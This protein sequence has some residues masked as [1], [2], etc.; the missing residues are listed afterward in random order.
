VEKILGEKSPNFLYSA[1]GSKKIRVFLRNYKL[2]DDIGFR[3]SARWWPEWPLTADKYAGWLAGAPGECINIFPDYET[4]GEHHWPE[5][6]IHSFLQHIPDEILKFE[7]LHMTTPSEVIAKHAPVDEIDVPEAGGTVSWA[8]VQRDQTG[9]LGNVM[10]WAYYTTLG[11]LEPFI[12]EAEDAEFL[13]L[14]RD[15]QTS[16]HLYYMFTAGGGPGEV[17]SYFSPFESPMDAFVSAQT[18]LN[19]FEVRLRLAILTANEPFLFYTGV[20]KQYYTETMAWSLKGFLKAI[21]EVNIKAIEFHA[22]NGDFESWAQSSLKDQKLA[23]QFKAIKGSKEKGE[24]LRE[25]ILDFTKKRY[26]ALNKQTQNA[27]KLF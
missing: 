4:F 23:S 1:K 19:E 2:I 9:W 26:I 27:T 12:K 11:R 14:W 3:F 13:R 21:R 18:L 6:G 10:Q 8:D 22:D 17:H 24:K 25:T 7:H 15:F 16:D 5:T 20:G